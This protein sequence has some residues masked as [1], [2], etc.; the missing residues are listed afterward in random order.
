MS[1]QGAAEQ[2]SPDFKTI[3]SI[4]TVNFYQAQIITDNNLQSQTTPQIQPVEINSAS[5]IDVEVNMN[6]QNVI[7][8]TTFSVLENQSQFFNAPQDQNQMSFNLQA[9][10]GGSQF[11][12][13]VSLTENQKN[14][15]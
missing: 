3:D 12:I 2:N 9:S 4:P 6:L 13:D 7:S 8:P 10:V 14:N 1:V 11:S 5:K 15:S